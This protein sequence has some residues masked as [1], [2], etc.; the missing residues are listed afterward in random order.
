MEARHADARVSWQT[1]DDLINTSTVD[2]RVAVARSHY[3][4][5]TTQV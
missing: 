2:T 3:N 5:Q 4:H 1:I